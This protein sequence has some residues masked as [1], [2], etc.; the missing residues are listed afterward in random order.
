MPKKSQLGVKK[1]GKRWQ[2]RPYIPGV[3]H[4]WAGTY[5]TEEE[6]TAAAEAK[7]AEHHTRPPRQETITS[8]AERWVRDFPRPKESTNDRY[9][10]DAKRFAKAVDPSDK[11][12]LH[13]VK[14]PEA[15]AYA[16][17]R[18]HD[19]GALRA[20]FSDARKSGLVTTNPF[21][22][23][24][25]SKGPGRSEMTPITE[26]ELDLMGALAFRSHG[27]EY[28]QVV[29]SLIIFAAETTMRPGE[30]SGLDRSDIDF[31]G[32]RVH[33]RRQF[34]K[35]RVQLPKSGKPRKLPYLPP[36][37]AQAIRDLPRRVPAPRCEVTG[38]EILF[39]G[40][41]GQ[42]ITQSALSAYW[43]PV[44]AAFEAAIPSDRLAEFEESGPSSLDFY[45][46]RH[47]GATRMVERGV[48]SWIV[49]KM[50]G[51]EDGGR[52][53]EKVY[54]HPRDEVARERLRKAFGENVRQLR[55]V[56]SQAEEATG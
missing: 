21:S 27:K 39:Y 28:G 22:E 19:L 7:V 32:E 2:A 16:Q 3:S 46:L 31:K 12:K 37:A 42:R 49:A 33:V 6:A 24:G 52:L 35:R 13:E 14:V 17:R 1:R 26:E 34:H 45:A 51:H 8:F 23:L 43:R 38:G 56:E 41:E 10:S 53:V 30:I 40:K 11:R 47:F 48:E 44:R 25:I 20:M 5:D 18:K 54:G 36:R 15:M 29:R 4:V 50:M 55:A 9:G